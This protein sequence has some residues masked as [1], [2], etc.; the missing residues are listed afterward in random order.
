MGTTAI[1]REMVQ[2]LVDKHVGNRTFRNQLE[3]IAGPE[4][5]IRVLGRYIQFNGIFGGGVANLAG[6]LAIRRDL[7][8]DPEEPIANIADKSTEV[9]ARVFAAAIDE[10]DDRR[11][12]HLDT[13]RM[14][15]QATLKATAEYLGIAPGT[16]VELI[17]RGAHATTLAIERVK[18][19]YGISETLNDQRLFRGLGFHM[20]SEILADAEFN[21]LDAY[22][23][24]QWQALAAHLEKTT[25]RLSGNKHN[26]YYWVFI[27]TS[28]EADHFEYAADAANTALRF[29]AGKD[30]RGLAASWIME[31]FERFGAVQSTFM[32]HL[33]DTD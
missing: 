26:A 20:G 33:S 6:E 10:F 15:A 28:V 1:T 11:M 24:E 17:S 13:H 25:V 18:A 7:F 23:K 12:P 29:Y 2:P 22:L 21:I 5:L 32:E 8:R 27:H 9:A 3:T 16:V 19:G 14:L 4:D 31:G 30:S